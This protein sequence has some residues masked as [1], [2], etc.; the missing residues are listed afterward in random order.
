MTAENEKDNKT[1]KKDDVTYSWFEKTVEYN[2]VLKS[3]RFF[4]LDFLSPFAGTAERMGDLMI[5]EGTRNYIIEFKKELES[6]NSE[7]VK[8]NE[9]TVGFEK[10]VTLLKEAGLLDKNAHYM[11]GGFLYNETELGLSIK[12][13][14]API[15]EK[16]TLLGESPPEDPVNLELKELKELKEDKGVD[17]EKPEDFFS[18]KS[19]FSFKDL[20][21]YTKIMT[22][23]RKNKITRGSKESQNVDES[24]SGES[25][26]SGGLIHRKIIAISKDKK[27]IVVDYEYFEKLQ[28]KLDMELNVNLNITAPTRAPG[29]RKK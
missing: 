29:M 6:M 26:S 4:E 18:D 17:V 5:Q 21:A 14:F 9:G 12:H 13:Y 7:Y 20:L 23:Q 1:Q 11:I 24:S 16:Y 27:S 25:S 22:S 3:N 10:T 2:F 8:Y 15:D 19:G 28:L